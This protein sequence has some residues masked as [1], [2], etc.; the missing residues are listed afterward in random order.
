MNAVSIAVDTIGCKLNQAE[1]DALARDLIVAGYRVIP[2]DQKADIY[3]LNTCTVTHIADRKARHLLRMAHRR[4]PEALIIATGCYA[5]R[6]SKELKGIDGMGIVIEDKQNQNLIELVAKAGYLPH[7]K[8]ESSYSFR[9]RAMIKIQQGCNRKCAYCIVPQ[10]RG[11]ELSNPIVQILNEVKHLT[12]DGFKEIVLTGTHI[13]SHDDLEKLVQQILENSQIK[14]LRLSSLQPADI[15][16]SL[17][18]LW[19]DERLCRHI[20]LPLQSGTDSVLV[21][22]GRWYSTSDFKNAVHLARKGIPEIS[23]TTDVIV[24]FP[25]ESDT[26]FEQS[27]DFCRRTEFANLHVFTYSP[28]PNTFASTMKDLSPQIKKGRSIKMLKLAEKLSQDYK[29][30]FIGQTMLVL[31]ESKT[32]RF[33]EGLTDNY[34]RVFA[35]ATKNLSNELLPAKLVSSYKSGLMG[36]LA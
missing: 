16:P 7:D 2:S 36:E 15:T 35:P 9:T 26:E 34:I 27:Y 21:R 17:L 10:T 22:M 28:R 25:G 12:V 14:R 5:K 8:C 6:A 20:H 29:N 11:P 30:R 23:I 31:W 18:K 3:I 24:G 1:S 4:N 32:G 33:M 13:G 19:Q